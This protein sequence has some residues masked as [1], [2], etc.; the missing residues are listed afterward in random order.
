MAGDPQPTVEA[1]DAG[2]ALTDYLERAWRE[3]RSG[4]IAGRGFHYQDAVGAWLALR[5][6]QG[7][8]E[9]DRLVPEGLED[10]SCEGPAG[11]QV[12]VKSRQARVGDFPRGTAARHV[13]DAWARHQEALGHEAPERLAVVFERPIDGETSRSWGVALASDEAWKNLAA[14]VDR[15]GRAQ[16]LVDSDIASLLAGTSVF[17]LPQH[18]IEEATAL[19]G[20]TELGG[21]TGA[22]PV[23][24]RAL[25]AAIAQHADA[26]AGSSWGERRGLSR[27]DVN[28]IVHE[29]VE[30]VDWNSLEDALRSGTCAPVDFGTPSTS[31]AFYEGESTQPGHLA[32]G[33]VVARP[34]PTEAVLAGLDA[35]RAVLV[36]GPSGIGKSAV[37][38]MAAYVARHV[39]W[40]RVARLGDDDVEPLL[41]LARAYGAGRYGPVGFVVDGVG[42]GALTAWDALRA[43]VAGQPGVLLLGSVREEDLLPLTS[44]HECAVV[45]PRL[46]EELAARIHEELARRGAT[47]QPHWRESYEQSNGLT[48]EYTHLLT[49]GERLAVVVR[50]QIDDRV[51]QRRDLEL[52]VLGPIALAHRWGSSLDIDLLTAQLGVAEPALKAALARLVQE[53]LVAVEGRVVTGLHPLRSAAICD[54]VHEIP[55]PSLAATAR[56][57]LWALPPGDL[58]GFL[59]GALVDHSGLAAPILEELVE[60]TSDEAVLPEALHG[61]RL[62]DFTGAA[63]RWRAIVVD[64]GIPPPMRSITMQL[65]LLDNDLRGLQQVL[66][67]RVA[68]G[69]RAIRDD[70]GNVSSALRDG[71]IG[72]L[73]VE[74]LTSRLAGSTSVADAIALLSVLAGSGLHLPIDRTSPVADVARAASLDDLLELVQAAGD[75]SREMGEWFLELTGGTQS[76]LER[77]L[78]ADPWLLELEVVDDGDERVLRGSRLHASDRLNPEPERTIKRLA[79]LG[80]GCLPGVDRAA[81]T[82]VWP[83]D[84][85]TRVGELDIA[86]TGLRTRYVR[87]AAE[88]EWNRARARAALALVA[89]ESESIR[90]STGADLLDKVAAFLD[91]LTRAWVLNRASG[92]RLDGLNRARSD[93]L[94][95]IEGLVPSS[96]AVADDGF[97]ADAIHSVAQ[98]AV[99]NL[100]AR[101]ADGSN[102][103]S[104]AAFVGDTLPAQLRRVDQEAW[105]LIGLPEPPPATARM[106]RLLADL[107]A[108]LAELAW[109]QGASTA[110]SPAAR[111]GPASDSLRRAARAA[112]GRA[113]KRH[114][115]QLASLVRLAAQHGVRVH[116]VTARD[117]EASATDWPPVRTG[118]VVDLESLAELDTTRLTL[119]ELLRGVLPT[120]K[121]VTLLP[122]RGGRTL[123][124]FAATAFVAGR[125]YRLPEEMDAWRDVA[126]DPWR[127]PFADFV[128]TAHQ[129]L[130][131]LSGIAYLSSRRSAGSQIQAAADTAAGEFRTAVEEIQRLPSDM[132]T[133]AVTEALL[134]LAGRVEAEGAGNAPGVLL[135]E[136]VVRGVALDEDNEDIRMLGALLILA[137]EWDIDPGNAAHLVE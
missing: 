38:W 7:E 86:S 18:E 101:L 55:P 91:D 49:R 87:G 111:S 131:E 102:L 10:I 3:R 40:F 97:G 61:L 16:G 41:R 105:Y 108:V 68:A 27:T 11:W 65:A 85:P 58:Q 1:D 77:M 126:P 81:L 46:D 50:Q 70:A 26:N 129:A 31:E 12:Q 116:P 117:A 62:A 122:A 28:R 60:R 29:T 9:F 57:V 8:L 53:H 92:R 106:R 17:V 136:S 103:A 113:D 74:E 78:D 94:A 56:I 96:P 22:A 33:L 52:A 107:H 133:T 44:Q 51:R 124:R 24:V 83:G 21:L 128:V 64:C 35:K 63:R 5:Q 42:V 118:L 127:T 2:E 123:P 137:T 80:L 19:V 93:L 132:V 23:V 25:R 89:A 114:D 45:R 34:L 6:Q 100:P 110:L 71:L 43:A 79:T 15:Q 14:E 13:L 99:Q 72:R 48:L 104:L 120:G 47:Q 67:P 20:A 84:L 109:G 121:K 39:Q 37:V 59:A 115:R 88:T 130:Q 82:T 73:G 98:G 75:V 112:R 66:D 30:L 135:A 125:L 119:A 90:L 32:A 95:E 54:A 4:A 36:T 69:I 76:L 134:E